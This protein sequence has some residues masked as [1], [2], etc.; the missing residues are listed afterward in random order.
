MR[1]GV[2][3]LLSR[4]RA[5]GGWGED[6][7]SYWQERR[8]EAKA[9]TPSQTAWA[10]LGLMAAGEVDHAAVRR[11]IELSSRCAAQGATSGIEPW[12]TAVGFPRIFYLR[13]HGYSAYFP[14][15]GSC[16]LPQPHALQRAHGRSTGM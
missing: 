12:Y 1:R 2:E 4:Q 14:A 5:D 9:S 8:A 6:G 16:A 13:Y 11:G 7:A 15:L 3:F 10:I